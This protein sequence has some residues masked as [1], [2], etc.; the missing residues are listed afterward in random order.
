MQ[1]YLILLLILLPFTVF[2]Q[3]KTD[4]Y[5]NVSYF[6]E[7][8][9]H[10]GMRLG[11][12]IPVKTWGENNHKHFDVAPS[13]GMFHHR[14]YQTGYFFLNDFTFR[15]NTSENK[16]LAA[17]LGLGFLNAQ[18][19]NTFISLS[20]GSVYEI[21]ANHWYIA[22]NFFVCFDKRI[23]IKKDKELDVFLKPQLMLA[24]P[25]F[26]VG[27]GYIVMEVGMRHKITITQ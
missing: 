3:N 12:N 13:I 23:S 17:G 7:M 19:P 4:L 18:T 5:I 1:K 6:G 11:M 20:E 26:P 8:I 15:R 10:P 21:D 14:R 27:L 9:T 2:G 22:I 16:C 24:Y 25:N